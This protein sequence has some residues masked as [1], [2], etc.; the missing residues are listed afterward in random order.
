MFLGFVTTGWIKDLFWISF[1]ANF[2]KVPAEKEG[3][4]ETNPKIYVQVPRAA[5]FSVADLERDRHSVVL[6]QS[7]VEAFSA[8]W[9]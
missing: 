7:L 9:M 1:S 6:V 2:K 8:M 4:G 5:K 3:R